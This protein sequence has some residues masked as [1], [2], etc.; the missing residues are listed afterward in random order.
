M[1]RR[2]FT[3]VVQYIRGVRTAVA[4]LRES[5]GDESPR[6]WRKEWALAMERLLQRTVRDGVDRDDTMDKLLIIFKKLKDRL[7]PDERGVCMSGPDGLQLLLDDLLDNFSSIRTASIPSML[8][9]FSVEPNTEFGTWLREFKRLVEGVKCFPGARL[10]DQDLK[11]HVMDC[12]SQFPP[13]T[14]AHKERLDSLTYP[15]LIEF[16]EQHSKNNLKAQEPSHT[17]SA[18]P[19]LS[20]F[21]TGRPVRVMTTAGAIAPM[22]SAPITA[23]VDDWEYVHSVRRGRPRLF[24]FKYGSDEQKSTAE[25][26]G[27]ICYNCKSPDHFLRNCDKPYENACGVFEGEFSEGSPQQLEDRWQSLLQKMREK[28]AERQAARNAK[29]N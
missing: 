22:P 11:L 2:S 16:L 28:H 12:L 5:A 7:R 25:K 4:S 19:G 13:I 24:K 15:D 1:D 14:V 9:E 27:A 17:T 29:P 18:E 20:S 23:H 21:Q 3:E 6:H 10:T 26:L 8:R